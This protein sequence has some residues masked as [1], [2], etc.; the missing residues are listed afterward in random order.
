MLGAK[1][2][3]EILK[4]TIGHTLAKLICLL[5]FMVGWLVGMMVF[6]SLHS[7]RLV[8]L[9]A[10]DV[11]LNVSYQFTLPYHEMPLLVCLAHHWLAGSAF[12]L[13]S[14]RVQQGLVAQSDM[15]CLWPLHPKIL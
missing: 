10:N 9:A 5:I 3:W 11:Y 4:V 15:L 8:L 7:S 2:A 13:T 6:M 1:N 12:E 14:V